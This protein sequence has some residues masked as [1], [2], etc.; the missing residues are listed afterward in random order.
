MPKISAKT[1]T[2]TND[3]QSAV[4]ESEWLLTGVIDTENVLESEGKKT[5]F[6]PSTIADIATNNRPILGDKFFGGGKFLDMFKDIKSIANKIH[7]IRPVTKTFT[8]LL[9]KD[10]TTTND[11]EEYVI[12]QTD[13]HINWHGG[14]SGGHDITVRADRGRFTKKDYIPIPDSFKVLTR[15][16]IF[17]IFLGTTAGVKNPEK[18]YIFINQYLKSDVELD[19]GLRFSF[20]HNVIPGAIEI[21]TTVDIKKELHSNDTMTFEMVVE[22]MCEDSI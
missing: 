12:G 21:V 14:V 9:N 19:V 22:F 10:S 2:S 6:N 20:T 8:W 11:F 16:Q 3:V 15:G 13:E 5:T 7:R 4:N 17:D 1:I 18:D